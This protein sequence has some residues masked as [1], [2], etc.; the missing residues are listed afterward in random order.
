MV[1]SLEKIKIAAAN[2]QMN[3][4]DLLKLAHVSTVTA[5]RIREGKEV[6]TKTAGKLAAALG[7]KVEAILHT[8]Q[9]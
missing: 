1:L 3:F 7:V 9:A 6:N 4:S 2:N 8:G 5:G